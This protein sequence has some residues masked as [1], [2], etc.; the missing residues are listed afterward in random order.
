MHYTNFS[1]SL[2][3]EYTGEVVSAEEAAARA[4]TAEQIGKDQFYQMKL[5]RSAVI[6]AT[7]YGNEARYINHSC[8]A[9]SRAEKVCGQ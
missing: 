5:T 4:T 7:Y 8:G 6:D 9:N 1:G 3:C 2:I